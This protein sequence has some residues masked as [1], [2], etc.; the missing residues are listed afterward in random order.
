M[1]EYVS[2]TWDPHSQCKES[3][4]RTRMES[5]YVIPWQS[6]HSRPK[7]HCCGT[8]TPETRYPGRV[9]PCPCIIEDKSGFDVDEDDSRQKGVHNEMITRYLAT[10]TTPALHHVTLTLTATIERFSHDLPNSTT[11]IMFACRVSI[12]Y[13]QHLI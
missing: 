2:T 9:R 11:L 3:F 6:L 4:T 5:D 1:L 13:I 12:S 7:P 8:Y 10:P